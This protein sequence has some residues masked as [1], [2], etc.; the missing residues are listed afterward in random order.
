MENEDCTF[1][2]RK[3]N[4]MTMPDSYSFPNIDEIF[5][6]LGGAKNFFSTLDPF[7]GYHQIWMDEG[8]IDLTCFETKFNNFILQSNTLLSY[9]CPSYFSKRNELCSL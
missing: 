5:D 4:A 6:I 9:W 8:S 3:L 1:D 7:S 2:Y